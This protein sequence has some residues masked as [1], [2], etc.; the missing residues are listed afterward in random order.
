MELQQ[1]F[2]LVE[3]QKASDLIIS[4]G[5]P[6][7]LR[8]NG[9][10]YRTKNESLTPEQAK[11][12]VFAVLTADQKK[13]FE[14]NKELDFSLASGRKH[15]FRV[16]V[17]LQKQA[18]TAAFRPIPDKIPSLDE[19]G[20]PESVEEFAKA[21]QGLILVTG[22]TGHGKTTT[23]ASILDLINNSRECHII[24][25]E[26][27]IEYVHQHKKSIVDQRE[28]GEDTHSFIEALKYV[29][30]QAPDV[31]LIGEMRDLETIQ[32]AL[33]AAETGHLV[34]ATLHTNDAIQTV[35]RVV[36]VFAAEQQQQVRFMLSMTLLAVISQRLIPR[37]DGKGRVLACELLKNTTAVANHIREGKTHQVYS[38]MEMAS[39][40]GMIT[41]DKAI[42]N[43]Y[44]EGLIS[45]EDA[46]AHVRNVKSIMDVNR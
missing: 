36:D 26:D 42:K 34:L 37:A 39:K 46:V 38:T 27:P 33:R 40:D 41:M 23:Q 32:A 28:V 35:D 8:V 11:Q 30:R 21:K 12:L 10:L 31:I 29:L 9:K 15:R 7:M 20:L 14:E 43:L 2:E 18:V 25:I 3:K 16:N 45:Y 22:P 13:Q 17:Y 19:L 4:A 1:L 5:A 6:P 44:M 24:T